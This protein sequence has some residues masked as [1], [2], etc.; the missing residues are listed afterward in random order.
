MPLST[1][2]NIDMSPDKSGRQFEP[3]R[4]VN[5]EAMRAVAVF[6]AGDVGVVWYDPEGKT[7][8]PVPVPGRHRQR[9]M[10]GLV[11]AP[12]ISPL[13]VVSVEFGR[14]DM[15]SDGYALTF[16][17]YQLYLANEH[18]AKTEDEKV[19][20]RMIA[21]ARQ[22][23]PI[24][25]S[26]MA[27]RDPARERDLAD[28]LFDTVQENNIREHVAVRLLA[29]AYALRRGQQG[30]DDAGQLGAR[31]DPAHRGQRRRRPGRGPARRVPVH[32]RRP[33]AARMADR[34][35]TVGAHRHASRGRGTILADQ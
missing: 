34:G 7:G 29:A 1:A 4:D 22:A 5:G 14:V 30:L 15:V 17:T 16:V 28:R 31:H 32:R 8:A 27:A 18:V 10:H 33:C 35:V 20:L 9:E 3:V 6:P 23:Y 12:G 24:F 11:Y 2:L 26:E 21:L 19:R 25:P 13:A